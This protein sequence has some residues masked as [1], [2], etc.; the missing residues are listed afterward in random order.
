MYYR[1]N[2]VTC[3]VML[4]QNKR[5]NR[6]LSQGRRLGDLNGWLDYDQI[7]LFVSLLINKGLG[8]VR[9]RL[10]RAPEIR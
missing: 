1:L 4:L 6:Q 10:Y 9:R 2:L 3:E 8:L 7:G 5:A